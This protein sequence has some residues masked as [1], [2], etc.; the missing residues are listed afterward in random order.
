MTYTTDSIL[1]IADLQALTIRQTEIA[2]AFLTH[3]DRRVR[4]QSPDLSRAAYTPA[5]PALF[6]TYE[7]NLRQL[8]R[9]YQ[10]EEIMPPRVWQGED[11]DKPRLSYVDA[12]R[13]FGTL[14]ALEG[15]IAGIGQRLPRTGTCHAAANRTRQAFRHI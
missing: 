10:T 4:L 2:A 14:D 11:M 5:Y 9:G 7:E 6:N 13:W 1:S 15:I 3:L 12:N 8:L